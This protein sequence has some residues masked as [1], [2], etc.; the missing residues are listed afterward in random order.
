[1]Q[2]ILTEIKDPT[3]P[4]LT[5]F[6]ALYQYNGNRHEESGKLPHQFYYAL[7]VMIKERIRDGV[8]V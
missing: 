6:L 3:S 1:M 8:A 7:A 5:D 4:T 2:S